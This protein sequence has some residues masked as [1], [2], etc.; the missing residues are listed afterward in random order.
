P[1][2]GTKPEAIMKIAGAHIDS[3]SGD[4]LVG[5]LRAPCANVNE[6]GVAALLEITRGLA[7]GERPM[8]VKLV[9]FAAEEVGAQGSRYYAQLTQTLETDVR[10][11][12]VLD[13]IGN[14]TGPEGEGSIRVFSAP[15]GA[16][17]ARVLARTVDVA[18]RL[19]LPEFVASVQ[20]TIDRPGRYSD[21]VPFS[22]A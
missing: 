6:S 13:M 11:V 12:L 4:W 3:G 5:A 19:Y 9:A 1:L 10:A 16:S 17:P 8:T 20:P 22:D 15:P 7:A 18:G 2:P 14:A 21:H